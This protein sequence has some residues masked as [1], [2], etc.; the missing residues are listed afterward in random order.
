[1]ECD[2]GE[3]IIIHNT[4]ANEQCI[5]IEINKDDDLFSVPSNKKNVSKRF[6]IG[7]SSKI[8][9]SN[10]L[11]INNISKNTII[12]DEKNYYIQKIKKNIEMKMKNNSILLDCHTDNKKI[13]KNQENGKMNRPEN[14]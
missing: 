14:T 11:K 9:Q 2:E 10:G 1:M 12:D 7:K 6:I 5:S 13:V 8:N 3:E 4:D